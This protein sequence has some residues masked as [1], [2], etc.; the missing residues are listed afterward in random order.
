MCD[1]LNTAWRSVARDGTAQPRRHQ[2]TQPCGLQAEKRISGVK[3]RQEVF[4][5][6][7][8]PLLLLRGGTGTGSKSKAR[9]LILGRTVRACALAARRVNSL[10]NI[11]HLRNR[12]SIMVSIG[13]MSALHKPSKS[14][15]TTLAR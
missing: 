11:H 12:G 5:D 3:A 4:E 2:R 9:L 14:A 15:T 7:D 8:N 1:L 13:Y 6:L 10:L